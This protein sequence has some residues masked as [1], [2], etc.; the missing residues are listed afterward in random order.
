MTLGRT[1]SL[2]L[3]AGRDNHVVQVDGMVELP[4]E[5][6]AGPRVQTIIVPPSGAITLPQGAVVAC[7][8]IRG[9]D[10]AFV[11]PD[12]TVI[13]VVDAAKLPDPLVV[14]GQ[15]ISMEG[16][17][18]GQPA[19]DISAGADK[20]GLIEPAAGPRVGGQGGPNYGGPQGSGG[21]FNK[22]DP[23]DIGDGI[24]GNDLLDPTENEFDVPKTREFE[25]AGDP[26]LS[27]AIWNLT[28]PDKICENDEG[29]G[30]WSVGYSGVTLAPDQTI[31]IKI[32]IE[33][34][35]AEA[36]DLTDDFFAALDAA[37]ADQAP[38]LITRT[39]NTLTFAAGAPTTL[40]FDLKAFDDNFVEGTET[41]KISIGGQSAGTIA[42]DAV[43]TEI[44]D[45]DNP[46]FCVKGVEAVIE[47]HTACYDIGITNDVILVDGQT[48]SVIL[49]FDPGTTNGGDFT[50]PFAQALGDA[51]AAAG[52][53]VED[54]GNGQ[55][56]L[57]FDENSDKTF[58]LHLPTADDL[59]AE[60]KEHFTLS[61]S[62]PS[63]G[64]TILCETVT[65]EICDNDSL[66]FRIAGDEC[67]CEGNAAS[68][69]LALA[70]GGGGPVNLCGDAKATVDL[71][72]CYGSTT[73]ADFAQTLY[74]SVLAAATAAG[75]G[76]DL[77]NDQ[78]LRFHFDANSQHNFS[79]LIPT[80][81][82][83]LVEG[84]ESF[85]LEL[86]DPTGPGSAI[87]APDAGS[88]TTGIRDNDGGVFSI[89]GD[90]HVCEGD[91]ASYTIA[92]DGPSLCGG[93]KVS[94]RLHLADCTTERAD[95]AKNLYESIL[96]AGKDAGVQVKY[97]GNYFVEL[98]F[99]ANSD[100]SFS[101]QVPTLDD[102]CVEGTECFVLVLKEPSANA[103]I[104]PNNGSQKT[105]IHD[106]DVS[107]AL[108]GSEAVCEG[109]AAHYTVA[110]N[111]GLCCG[112]QACVN[113]RID[114]WDTSLADFQKNVL[115]PIYAAGDAQ[116]VEVRFRFINPNSAEVRITF[117]GDSDP[118]FDFC[119]PTKD[120]CDPE[121][122]ETFKVSLGYPSDNAKIVP[123]KGEV[124]TT[125]YDN[126]HFKGQLFSQGEENGPEFALQQE[127][128]NDD[129]GCAFNQAL[130][131]QGR[132]AGNDLVTQENDELP[133][134]GS[135]RGP[136]PCGGDA[137][138]EVTVALASVQT[139]DSFANEHSNA[140]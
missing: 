27:P 121:C 65:T 37:I 116:G 75:I 108:Y 88:V 1:P 87:V 62:D 38:G 56:R 29:P 31:S 98:V 61:L 93:E 13:L 109:E 105:Y 103:S 84:K 8:E 21:N 36:A 18:T 131:H 70:N 15:P 100:K 22:I 68:Y 132:V 28:G 140:A 39:G 57:T 66:V 92:Y 23:G 50:K 30:T 25:P 49:T 111:G 6:A 34:L 115:D 58:K 74:N 104:D 48:A 102:R 73:P 97:I 24:R 135:D 113:I 126:D 33:F 20:D 81:Q 63:N 14:N 4:L 52:V 69:T 138:V 114:F 125:I 78:L 85:T 89:Q 32:E 16:C 44:C 139:I 43:N 82:D 59:C 106:N 42:N 83:K 134:G 79:F 51:A 7:P 117:N 91:A 71:K 101:F 137:G 128:S 80:Q 76:V 120:D 67:V 77:I 136:G 19:T 26:D 2:E 17:P 11:Q 86:Q 47:G 55:F 90:C 129:C 41:F 95:F 119:L 53:G 118:N 99:D 45:P 130:F 110:M 46:Q 64:A 54:L 133:L 3:N 9:D 5:P 94:V 40:Y 107:F 12:G 96:W 10:I 112:E 123:G 35:T 124:E 122:P 127:P 72:L 60:G